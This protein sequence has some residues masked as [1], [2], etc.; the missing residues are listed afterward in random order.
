MVHVLINHGTIVVGEGL[1]S[2]WRVQPENIKKPT[3]S[4]RSHM[5]GE[6]AM[7]LEVEQLENPSEEFDSSESQT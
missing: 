3:F 5:G 1:S 2:Q 6:S 7:S 4:G